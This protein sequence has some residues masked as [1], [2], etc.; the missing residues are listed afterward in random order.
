MKFWNNLKEIITNPFP[1]V[2]TYWT[3][4]P[5]TGKGIYVKAK[6]YK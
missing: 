4:D 6:H 5:K 3:R 1:P 2:E